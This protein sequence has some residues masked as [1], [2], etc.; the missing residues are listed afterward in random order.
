MLRYVE[1]MHF[2][3][4]FFFFSSLFLLSLFQLRSITT[5]AIPFA[6]CYC[7]SS[8]CCSFHWSCL[9]PLRLHCPF[10]VSF[11]IC[12]VLPMYRD[13]FFHCFS[14]LLFCFVLFCV[15]LFFFS[16]YFQRN[17]FGARSA[18][19]SVKFHAKPF[20]ADPH[21]GTMFRRF[22]YCDGIESGWIETN[23]KEWTR[24]NKNTLF[25]SFCPMLSIIIKAIW[26]FCIEHTANENPVCTLHSAYTNIT[27]NNRWF[28][29][30]TVFASTSVCN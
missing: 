7:N 22:L 18:K 1:C 25:F 20:K 16:L 4:M 9:F 21:I 5:F 12:W 19:G 13:F 3:C 24:R 8:N 27:C 6:L 15:V 28:I 10:H 23:R 30:L 11:L 26:V 2:G 17:R 14:F 29:S